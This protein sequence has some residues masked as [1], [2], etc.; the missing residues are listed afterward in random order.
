VEK[1]E[2]LFA[3]HFSLP[4]ASFVVP[5]GWCWRPVAQRRVWTLGVVVDP[6][7]FRQHLHLLEGVEDFALRSNPTARSHGNGYSASVAKDSLGSEGQ[8]I[9]HRNLNKQP[10][11]FSTS[12]SSPTR[13]SNP[14]GDEKSAPGKHVAFEFNAVGKYG[15][16]GFRTSRPALPGVGRIGARSTLVAIGKSFVSH[17]WVGGIIIHFHWTR[18]TIS[19]T[20]NNFVN[21]RAWTCGSCHVSC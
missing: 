7:S 8:P 5:R 4:L 6:P 16:Q 15:A 11:R 13:S 14:I 3:F 1:W 2:A 20:S 9:V 18:P 19:V 12:A 10:D 17:H 21:F